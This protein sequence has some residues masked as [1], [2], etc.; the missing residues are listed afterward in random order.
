MVYVRVRACAGVHRGRFIFHYVLSLLI[1]WAIFLACML[2]FAFHQ[3]HVPIKGFGEEFKRETVFQQGTA[4]FNFIVCQCTV[5]RSREGTAAE[6][7]RLHQ[8][9]SQALHHF[10]SHCTHLL[11]A[12]VVVCLLFSPQS[13]STLVCVSA[14]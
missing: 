1:V 7:R 2:S 13:F 3:L 12:P 10:P 11:C 5:Q 9:N 4:M 14:A 6:T 8:R